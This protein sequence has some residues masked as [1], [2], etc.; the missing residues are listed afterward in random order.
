MSHLLRSVAGVAG[1]H[2][3]AIAMIAMMW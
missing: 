2:I 3:I 1:Y